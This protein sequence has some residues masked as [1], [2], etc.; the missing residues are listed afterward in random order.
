MSQFHP[1]IAVAGRPT[2][3]VHPLKAVLRAM[4]TTITARRTATGGHEHLPFDVEL[5]MSPPFGSSDARSS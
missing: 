3:V 2:R 1:A 5:Y 4:S